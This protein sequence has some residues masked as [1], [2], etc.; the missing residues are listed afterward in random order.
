MS[1]FANSHGVQ[2][3]G[4][5]F[6]AI[7]G[8]MN[9]DRQLPLAISGNQQH[10]P[11]NPDDPHP[12]GTSRADDVSG[13]S[14]SPPSGAQRSVRNV[15]GTRYH[16][17]ASGTSSRQQIASQAPKLLS[18]PQAS[19]SRQITEASRSENN[20]IGSYDRETHGETSS[21]SGALILT[22]NT[23]DAERFDSA[24]FPQRL[25]ESHLYGVPRQVEPIGTGYVSNHCKA[26]PPNHPHPGCRLLPVG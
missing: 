20:T 16:P 7:A 2:I 6:Y 5:N 17:Y 23:T 24:F 21:E 13:T 8:S 25:P 3:N 19:T 9:I 14:Y 15:G 18:F 1:F 12:A 4:G 26:S 11:R 22:H 10:L